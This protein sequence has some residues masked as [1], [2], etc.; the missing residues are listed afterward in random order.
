[1]EIRNRFAILALLSTNEEPR[2]TYLDYENVPALELGKN[3]KQQSRNYWEVPEY[4]EKPFSYSSEVITI[5]KT[6]SFMKKAKS[7][8]PVEEA[9]LDAPIKKENPHDNVSKVSR[10]EFKISLTN[11]VHNLP[12]TRSYYPPQPYK[13]KQNLFRKYYLA[14]K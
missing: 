14:H 13:F 3:I 2:E 8:A 10:D 6:S 9:K 12:I 4:V 11:E 5:P 7:V 1:M